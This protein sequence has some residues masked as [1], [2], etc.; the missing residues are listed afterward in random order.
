VV[1][2]LSV[3]DVIE[4]YQVLIRDFEEDNDP[5]SPAGVRDQGLLESAVN[6][7]HTGFGGVFKYETP[8]SSA[9]SLCYGICCDHAFH[10]GNKRTALVALLVHLDKNELCLP[11][12]T[13]DELYDLMLSIADHKL[14]KKPNE[15]HDISD[16]EVEAIA[17]WL[18]KRTAK[19]SKGERPITYRQLRRILS[20][21]GIEMENAG[22]NQAE[23]VRYKNERVGIFKKRTERRRH[24]VATIG[25]RDE[26]TQLSKG[27]VKNIRELCGLTEADGVDSNMFYASGEIIDSFVNN[28][29][30][31]LRRLARV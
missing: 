25:Y 30:K 28:Y 15:R 20:G 6:R 27:E 29:R 2:T 17:R 18:R 16:D 4:I 9:A 12:T 1:N 22:Q 7:Q 13:Q 19:V 21:Y 8:Y 5:I 14:I 23:L 31:L 10:N 24:K 3:Q 26:G 11:S